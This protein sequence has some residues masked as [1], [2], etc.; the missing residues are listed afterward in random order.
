MKVIESPLRVPTKEKVESQPILLE[1]EWERVGVHVGDFE[2]E[3]IVT[4]ILLKRY[5][6]LKAIGA[7]VKDV[8]G[9]GKEDL[10]VPHHNIHH[11][12]LTL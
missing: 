2:F 11:S 4:S 8:F 5:L 3:M 6:F 9:M 12:S 1:Q 10:L 7:E